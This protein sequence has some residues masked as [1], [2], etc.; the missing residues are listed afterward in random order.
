MSIDYLG[1]IVVPGRRLPLY[2]FAVPAGFPSPAQDHI[3]REISLDELLGLR[4][5]QIYMVRVGGD[6]MTGVGIFDGD[7]AVVDRALEAK[8]GFIVIATLNNEPLI[9]TL[10]K[11]GDQFILRPENPAFAP[12]YVLETDE[13]KICGVVLYSI[14][15]HSHARA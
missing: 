13:L 2:S 6:S 8:P 3:E 11:E 15:S 10:C 14:R 9:K 5:P 4:L 12:R 1:H 7:L